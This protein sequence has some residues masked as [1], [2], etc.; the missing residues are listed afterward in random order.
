[1]NTA[2]SQQI[3]NMIKEG[4]LEFDPSPRTRI[5]KDLFTSKQAQGFCPILMIMM[6]ANDDWLEKATKY[7]TH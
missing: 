4:D 5:L 2:Y 7:S 1:M 3:N 6:D